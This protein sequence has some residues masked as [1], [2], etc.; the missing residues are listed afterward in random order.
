VRSRYGA[1]D[2][3]VGCHLRLDINEPAIPIEA[4][5]RPGV[6]SPAQDRVAAEAQKL[7][8]SVTIAYPEWRATV[9]ED[10]HYSFAIAL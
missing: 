9:D 5:E 6:V 7:R 10:G 8:I 1:C 4:E 2:A 3:S